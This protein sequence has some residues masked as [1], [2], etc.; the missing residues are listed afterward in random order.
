MSGLCNLNNLQELDMRLV[1]S[2]LHVW[3]ML[4]EN[5]YI[6]EPTM[7]TFKTQVFSWFG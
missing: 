3:Q 4:L 2:Y 5:L 7:Q 6:I 1:V